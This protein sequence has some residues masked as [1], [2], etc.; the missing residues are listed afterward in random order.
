MGQKVNPKVIRIGITQ[1]GMRGKVISRN[2][3]IKI[4][5]LKN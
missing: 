1:D 4:W 5:P 3:S 2:F